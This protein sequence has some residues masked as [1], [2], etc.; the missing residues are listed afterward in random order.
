MERSTNAVE[1]YVAFVE[2]VY[3]ADAFDQRRFPCPVVA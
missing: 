2:R 3:A 1:Q